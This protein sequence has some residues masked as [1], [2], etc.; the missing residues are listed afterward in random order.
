MDML[1]GC[2]C[3]ERK[4]IQTRWF[5]GCT[6]S[7][8]FPPRPCIMFPKFITHSYLSEISQMRYLLQEKGDNL[9]VPPMQGRPHGVP[10]MWECVGRFGRG[11][12]RCEMSL[13]SPAA[14]LQLWGAQHRKTLNCVEHSQ[15]RGEAAA[16]QGPCPCFVTWFEKK[17][18]SSAPIPWQQSS[19]ICAILQGNM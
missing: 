5:L 14:P 6:L 18:Y 12:R 19:F 9:Q 10:A 2:A 8:V 17:Q 11:R 16:Q 15:D 13:P 7:C 1:Q 4:E 3:V